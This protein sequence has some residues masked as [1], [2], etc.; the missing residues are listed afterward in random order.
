MTHAQ[1]V[2]TRPFFL[3]KG[4]G[5]RLIGVLYYNIM[6]SLASTRL[7][8]PEKRTASL[9]SLLVWGARPLDE[10]KGRPIHVS[11]QWNA[12]SARTPVSHKPTKCILRSCS[13]LEKENCYLCGRLLTSTEDKKRRSKLSNPLLQGSLRHFAL[14]V[15]EVRSEVDVGIASKCS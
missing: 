3:G 9:G 14:L 7:E 1:T 6:T 5:T 4:V 12:I 8:P 15:H 10:R 2:D 11:F 13:W